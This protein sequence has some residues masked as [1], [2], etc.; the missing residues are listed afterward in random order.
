MLL[1]IDQN[2]HNF[3]L[4]QKDVFIPCKGMY[5]IQIDQFS[6]KWNQNIGTFFHKLIKLLEI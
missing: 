3:L 1:W 2:K 4:K 5:Y 6:I